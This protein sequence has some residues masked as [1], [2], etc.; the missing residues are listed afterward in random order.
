MKKDGQADAGCPCPKTFTLLYLSYPGTMDL[1]TC[2]SL[3]DHAVGVTSPENHYLGTAVQFPALVHL[4]HAYYSN[5]YFSSEF[6]LK[7]LTILLP[8][9]IQI[10][11][12]IY[13]C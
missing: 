6:L 3:Y 4:S 2:W 5:V 12:H 13:A 9:Q 1:I 8:V 10:G 11:L 7:L